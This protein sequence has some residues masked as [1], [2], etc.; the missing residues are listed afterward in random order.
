MTSIS[1]SK[2]IEWEIGLKDKTQKCVAYKK[3]FSLTKTNIVLEY[4][5]G[6]RSFKQTDAKNK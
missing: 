5:V 1:Q 4:K 2:H 3:C 6:K